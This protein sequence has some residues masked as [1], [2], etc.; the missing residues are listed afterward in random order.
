MTEE[1]SLLIELQEL[2]TEL[3]SRDRAM[4]A[5]PLRAEAVVKPLADARS[6]VEYHQRRLDDA[7]MK[8]RDREST[9]KEAAERLVKL[10]ERTAQV[11]DTK[12]FNA[13]HREVEQTERDQK[14]AKDD[15][16]R[17]QETINLESGE[18]KAAEA[19]VAELEGKAAELKQVIELEVKRIDAELR[20]L[21]GRRAGI[22]SRIDKGTYADYMRILKRT[23]GVAVAAACKGLCT[24]CHM[25][26]MPQLIVELQ[27][28][29]EI[30][31]CPQCGR[32]IYYKVDED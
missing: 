23:M 24:G 6:A 19:R 29:N 13:H 14:K 31:Y 15:A 2:D 5:I 21:K 32:I 12:A 30:T 7:Q 4:K 20:E 11:K 17:L 8:K 27:N 10:K 1:L 25:N 26:I 18:V 16:A 3:I 9:G 22:V 28:T